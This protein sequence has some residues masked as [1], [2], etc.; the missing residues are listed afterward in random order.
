MS[1]NQTGK[2]SIEGGFTQFSFSNQIKVPSYLIALAVGDL[3]K[4]SLGNRVNLITEP[5]QLDSAKSEL[6][7]L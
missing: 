1:A 2:Q 6:S 5:G 4:V 3:K 7:E